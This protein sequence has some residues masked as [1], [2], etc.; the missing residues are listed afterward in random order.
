MTA[1]HSC[2]GWSGAKGTL[3]AAFVFRGDGLRRFVSPAPTLLMPG[4]RGSSVSLPAGGRTDR[5]EPPTSIAPACGQKSDASESLSRQG[6][7]AGFHSWG[8]SSHGITSNSRQCASRDVAPQ[9]RAARKPA[10][11]RQQTVTTGPTP[12]PG[13]QREGCAADSHSAVISTAS[14]ATSWH[15]KTGRSPTVV[16]R[17]R[18][19]PA[20]RIAGP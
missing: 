12:R 15:P 7:P 19:N 13:D 3:P 16:G 9:V 2:C 17:F 4:G 10:G 18:C 8:N 6:E 14:K 11:P 1:S 5:G 20:P